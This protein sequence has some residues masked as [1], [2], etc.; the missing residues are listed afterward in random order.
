MAAREPRKN[1]SK[2][3]RFEVFKRDSFKCQYCG[4]VSPDVLLHVD[5]IKP[6]AEGGA[7]ELVNLITACQAC[8]LGKGA[9]TLDDK[10][11]INKTRNQMEELQERREQIEMMMEW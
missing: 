3:I 8:N 11:V 2:K 10:S 9:R 6:V 5:H 7:N 1:I 4:R